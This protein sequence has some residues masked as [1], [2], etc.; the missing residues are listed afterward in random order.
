[1]KLKWV[2][3]SHVTCLRQNTW[4][5]GDATWVCALTVVLTNPSPEEAVQARTRQ[6][7][8]LLPATVPRSL[9]QSRPR[10]VNWFNRSP[11]TAVWRLGKEQPLLYMRVRRQEAL[12]ASGDHLVVPREAG[13]KTVAINQE[14]LSHSTGGTKNLL[15]EESN[16]YSV[17]VFCYL[18]PKASLL[19]QYSSRK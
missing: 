18:Q 11:G 16:S 6:H 7:D 9:A 2:H 19:I 3:I 8:P 12:T 14:T 5:P 1:M 10:N 4:P 15:C 13:W 17:W